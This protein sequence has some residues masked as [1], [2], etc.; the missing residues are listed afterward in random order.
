M[1]EEEHENRI[2]ENDCL[3]LL[4]ETELMINEDKLNQN[5]MLNIISGRFS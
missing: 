4:H 3:N 2:R 5:D 1:T